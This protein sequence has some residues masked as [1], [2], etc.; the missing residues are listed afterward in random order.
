L[1]RRHRGPAPVESERELVEVDLQVR[2]AH[3]VMGPHEPRLEIAEDRCMR[4]KRFSARLG[5]PWGR[6]RGRYPKAARGAEAGQASV[7]ASA[8]RSTFLLTK[9]VR[10]APEALGTTCS[11][12]RP[13]EGPRSSTAATTSALSTSGRPPRRPASGSPMDVSSTSTWWFNRSRSG[14]TMARRSLCS[15]AQAVSYRS[16]PSCRCSWR[17]ERPGVCVVMAERLSEM[18]EEP[19]T[20][21]LSTV[22]SLFP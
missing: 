6:A 20:V 11:R 1:E 2:V 9:P 12:T 8:P 3:T 22:E 13:A 19:L 4:G 14:R 18:L 17:A 10:E 15:T 7:T 5:S 21:Y 16:I